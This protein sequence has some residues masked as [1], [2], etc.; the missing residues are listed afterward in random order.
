MASPKDDPDTQLITSI[1]D[2]ANGIDNNLQTD[3]ILLDFYKAF[4]NVLHSLLLQKLEPLWGQRKHP[5]MDGRLPF[6]KNPAG[7]P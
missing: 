1:N 2:L 7:C 6:I 3:A 5:L 4:D